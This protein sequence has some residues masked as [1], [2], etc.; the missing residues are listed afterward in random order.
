MQSQDEK[1]HLGFLPRPRDNAY[2]T[3]HNAKQSGAKL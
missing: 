3:G 1:H 2:S